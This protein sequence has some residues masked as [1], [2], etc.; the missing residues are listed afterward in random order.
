MSIETGDAASLE[1]GGRFEWMLPFRGEGE[2]RHNA[3][4]L[5]VRDGWVYAT[6]GVVAVRSPGEG[7]D[8]Q[9]EIGDRVWDGVAGL[10]WPALAEVGYR[11]CPQMVVPEPGWSC[12]QCRACVNKDFHERV[13]DRAWG[14][15]RYGDVW[16]NEKYVR[17]VAKASGQVAAPSPTQ[18]ASLKFPAGGQGFL[19]PINPS[20]IGGHVVAGDFNEGGSDA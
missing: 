5:F 19:M 16:L 4:R 2:A 11:K 10:N 8:Y 14:V 12:S 9:G 7:G 20:S 1:A 6:D 15:V 17:M 18:P 13:P 3:S